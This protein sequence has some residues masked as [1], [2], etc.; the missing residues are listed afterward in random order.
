MHIENTE[1]MELC[2]RF[3]ELTGLSRAE[4]KPYKRKGFHD[5]G[6]CIDVYEYAKQMKEEQDAR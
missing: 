6:F 4:M 3:L 2:E 5:S 1:M